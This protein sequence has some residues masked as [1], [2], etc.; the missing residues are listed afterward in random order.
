MEN[1]YKVHI[2]RYAFRQMEEIKNYV[3]YELSAPMAA[4]N[5]LTKMKQAIASLETMPERNPL[6]DEKTW[7]SQGIRRIV[8]KN[9]LVYYWI[10]ENKRIVYITAV[11]YGRRN[12]INQLGKMDMDIE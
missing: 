9:F 12:Q 6:I 5:L 2:T 10:D 4:K 3:A 11:I 8:V 1:L 7:R